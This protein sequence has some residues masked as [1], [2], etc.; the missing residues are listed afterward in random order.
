MRTTPVELGAW[1]KVVS[2][3]AM[4][5]CDTPSPR[6]FVLKKIRSPGL[7]SEGFTLLPAS[8]PLLDHA[9]NEDAVLREYILDE[10]AA[11]ETRGIGAPETVGHAAESHREL[12]DRFAE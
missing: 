8:V 5:T 6:F 2:S 10:T 9:R 11:I 3:M 4:A 12:N 1:T 7:I